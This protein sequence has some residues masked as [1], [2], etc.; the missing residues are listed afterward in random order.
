LYQRLIDGKIQK[1]PT[2]IGN[3]RDE[4]SPLFRNAQ[5]PIISRLNHSRDMFK[6]ANALKLYKNVFGADYEKVLEQYPLN[7]NDIQNEDSIVQML[8]D[9]VFACSSNKVID[10]MAASKIPTYKYW[11][12][13]VSSVFLM[14]RCTRNKVC[15]AT[16]LPIFWR[17]FWAPLRKRERDLSD[18]LIAY[19]IGFAQGDVNKHAKKIKWKRYT[20]QDKNYVELG[21]QVKALKGN[22]DRQCRI[23]NHVLGYKY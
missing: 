19:F 4:Q 21:D 11:Y 15:H 7:E 22:R 8:S 6:L 1:V 12:T 20:M 16:E 5:W 23:W 14:G 2:L 13:Q 3:N 10:R 9:Y 17:P 18:Q